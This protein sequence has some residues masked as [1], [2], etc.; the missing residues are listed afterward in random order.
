MKRLTRKIKKK[1][2]KE[3][4]NEENHLKQSKALV[5]T[6]GNQ[7]IKKAKAKPKLSKQANNK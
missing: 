7:I 2:K 1:K 4:Q 5:L 3:K 6:R